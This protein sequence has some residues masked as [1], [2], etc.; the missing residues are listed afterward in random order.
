[1]VALDQD[2]VI[3]AREVV[4]P[5]FDHVDD[6]QE[7]PMIRVVVLFGRRAFSRVQIDRSKDPESVVLVKDGGDCEAT[8]IGLQHDRILQ[9]E[10]LE[11]QWD[12]KFVLSFRNGSSAY[13][14]DSHFRVRCVFS[15][16]DIGAITF[17]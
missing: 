8:C 13:R 15:K 9:D 16:V 7:L 11:N 10:M 14:V 3:G 5:L 1:M 17:A 12:G 6:C 2:L 4:Y